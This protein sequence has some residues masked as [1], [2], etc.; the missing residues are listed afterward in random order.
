MATSDNS[1]MLALNK[2]TGRVH[3][4][5]GTVPGGIGADEMGFGIGIAPCGCDD[6]HFKVAVENDMIIAIQPEQL[7]VGIWE[8]APCIDT[9]S[10]GDK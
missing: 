4:Y 7:E 3:K 5:N 10:S 1:E 9:D 6:D 2:A 8:P